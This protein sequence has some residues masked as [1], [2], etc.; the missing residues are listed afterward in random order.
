M[1]FSYYAIELFSCVLARLIYYPN[2][3]LRS[4]RK[5]NIISMMFFLSP[6]KVTLKSQRLFFKILAGKVD[7]LSQQ[8]YT[9]S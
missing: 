1:K 6:G 5:V 7:S 8:V 9:K 3:F 4:L 2:K